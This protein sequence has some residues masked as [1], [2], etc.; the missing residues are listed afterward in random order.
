MMP[1]SFKENEKENIIALHLQTLSK[2]NRLLS[3]FVSKLRF[4]LNNPKYYE[5]IHWSPDGKAIIITDVSSFKEKILQKEGE[6]F[7]TQNFSSFVRQLNLY[8]FRKI[9]GIDK[10]DTFKNMKFEHSYFRRERPDLMHL[11]QRTC[12]PSRHKKSRKCLANLD[13]N[14]GTSRSYTQQKVNLL[15]EKENENSFRNVPSDRVLHAKEKG[16][17]ENKV[18]IDD[19]CE[20]SV[21]E[22]SIISLNETDFGMT[23]SLEHDYALPQIENVYKVMDEETVYEYLD[24]K[25]TDEKEVVQILLGLKD[26]ISRDMIHDPLSVLAKVSSEVVDLTRI[27]SRPSF[28]HYPSSTPMQTITIS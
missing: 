8:G 17:V 18:E 11:V 22:D 27:E 16:F 28:R 1:V 15:S 9:S 21:I 5:V 24:Q 25:F 20:D 7:K 13:S 3:P 6:M 12:L 26:E 2:K 10:C 4:L 14:C 23:S 19:I